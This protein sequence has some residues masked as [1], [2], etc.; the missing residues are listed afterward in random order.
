MIDFTITLAGTSALLMHNS[1]LSNPLDP[2]TKALKAV[3]GKRMKTDDDH[4]Q[5]AYLEFCGGLYHD[6]QLGPYIPGENI[7]RA[8]LDGAKLTKMGTR[9]TRGLFIKSDV[10]PLVDYGGPRDVTGLWERGFRHMA[11][12]KNGQNR[13][14][15]TRPWF[16]QWRVQADGVLDPSVLELAD[17]VA[18]ADNAGQF[19]G[20]GDWRPRFGRFTATV[21]QVA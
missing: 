4:Q 7:A 12:A 1:R 16:P 8:L 2:A 9:V 15:R 19:I 21:E 13:I 11:S 20:L 14:M 6:E 5:I 17:L 18:I 3:T 10:N